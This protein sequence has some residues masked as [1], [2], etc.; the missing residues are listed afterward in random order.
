M[1]TSATAQ[2]ELMNQA[3]PYYKGVCHIALAQEGHCRLDEVLLGT[4]SHMAMLELLANL[5]LELATLMQVLYWALASSS[6][7]FVNACFTG[8]VASLDALVKEFLSASNE[9]KKAIFSWIVGEADQLKGSTARY[10]KIYL[11]ATKSFMEKG[12]D[13]AK[14]EMERLQRMLNKSICPA[15]ATK[16]TLKKNILSTFA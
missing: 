8:I 14:N 9:E 11:K 7:R 10:G 15:K 12:A 3:N 16:F 1:M 6:S 5:L 13:Y 2:V 4:D